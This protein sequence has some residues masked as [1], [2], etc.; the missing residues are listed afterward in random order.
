MHNQTGRAGRLL[1]GIVNYP[2]HHQIIADHRQQQVAVHQIFVE[3]TT[4][5]KFI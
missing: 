1:A 5:Y 4:G 2:N 3:E